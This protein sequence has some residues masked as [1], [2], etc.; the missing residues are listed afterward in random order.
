M[1]LDN[2]RYRKR[3]RYT[4]KTSPT[5]KRIFKSEVYVRI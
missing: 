4:C 1:C 3:D 2:W 5:P